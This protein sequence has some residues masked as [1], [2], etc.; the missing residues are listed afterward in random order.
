MYLR[1]IFLCLANKR[2]DIDHNFLHL[3]HT[4]CIYALVSVSACQL[5][6]HFIHSIWVIILY[7]TWYIEISDKSYKSLFGRYLRFHYLSGKKETIIEPAVHDKW[8]W[9]KKIILFRFV[10]FDENKSCLGIIIVQSQNVPNY[11]K[12]TIYLNWSMQ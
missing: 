10:C 11:T 3:F 6:E 1:E 8:V 9:G 5:Y 7:W 4:I 2:I 12:S